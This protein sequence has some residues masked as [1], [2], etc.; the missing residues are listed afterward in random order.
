MNA[1]QYFVHQT[2]GIISDINS[3]PLNLPCGAFYSLDRALSF[4]EI[5][6]DK[7]NFTAIYD[8]NGKLHTV[9]KGK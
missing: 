9:L 6:Q 5:V 1:F 3:A 2:S 4:A 8:A 7:L